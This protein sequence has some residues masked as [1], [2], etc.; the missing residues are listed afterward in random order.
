[1]E[2]KE[3]S[4]APASTPSYV[5]TLCQTLVDGSEPGAVEYVDSTAED[6]VSEIVLQLPNLVR[7]AVSKKLEHGDK[8]MQV[9]H[10]NAKD[11]ASL[12]S[13]LV[14]EKA[15]YKVVLCW[16]KKKSVKFLHH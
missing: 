6:I 2:S 13:R 15:E 3:T 1:M 14:Q 5:E 9:I 10:T 8:K 16:T 7:H 12:V 4:N 11:L